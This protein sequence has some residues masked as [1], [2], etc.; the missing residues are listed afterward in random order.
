MPIKQAKKAGSKNKASNTKKP[1]AI[2]VQHLATQCVKIAMNAVH[3]AH[4]EVNNLFVDTSTAVG[5]IAAELLDKALD[6]KID[7][8]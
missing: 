6:G 3:A 8:K 2:Q 7:L 1:N 4:N 5:R